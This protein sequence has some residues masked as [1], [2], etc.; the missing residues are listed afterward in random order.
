MPFAGQWVLISRCE[1]TL[2]VSPAGH[3]AAL[4]SVTD[5]V[6][7]VVAELAA[8]DTAYTARQWVMTHDYNYN[9]Y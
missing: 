2:L 6:V 9:N 5:D 8:A 3:N 1:S 7:W 4:C